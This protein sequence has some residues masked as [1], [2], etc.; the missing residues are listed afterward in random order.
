MTGPILD[1]DRVQVTI[2]QRLNGTTILNTLLYRAQVPVEVLSNSGNFILAGLI[3][4][5]R[6]V[7]GIV[8]EMQA[9]QTTDLGYDS[10]TAQVVGP[11]RKPYFRVTFNEFGEKDP[12]TLPTGV[13]AVITKRSENAGRGRSGAF[14]LG[15][16]AV[17]DTL[18][19]NL[20]PAFRLALATLGDKLLEVIP[21]VSITPAGIVSFV[22][23]MASDPLTSIGNDV[24]AC[25][26]QQT[27]RYMT[28]RTLGRGI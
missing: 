12:P 24:I 14:H 19:S 25:Q 28:R 11:V 4:Y 17:E 27:V 15:G 16:I 18:D 5:I 20:L 8:K 3:A 13:D 2:A 1:D 23:I 9:N 7:G 6:G 10:V 22:P 26:V 21:V